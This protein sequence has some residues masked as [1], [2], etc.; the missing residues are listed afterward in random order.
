MIRSLHSLTTTI[1]IGVLLAACG[2]STSAPPSTASPLTS[3]PPGTSP[4]SSPQTAMIPTPGRVAAG[5]EHTCALTSGDGVKCWGANNSGQLGDGTMTAFGVPVTLPADVSGLASGVTA[6]S[7][8]GFHSCA[9]TDAGGVKCWGSNEYGQLGDGT[10]ITS[11]VPVDVS[12][13]ASGVLMISAGWS[14]TCALTSAGGVKCW[15]NNPFGGLGNGT[16]DDSS[17]PVDVSGLDGGI[18]AIA[19]G[20]LHAC[21]LRRTGGVT[22]WGYG[23]SDDPTLFSS[24]LPVEV[25]GLTIGISAIS[26]TLDQTCALRDTGGV[27]CWGPNYA[28]PPGETLPD[29][30]VPVNVA[31]AGG[32]SSIAVGETHSCAL[33][34]LGAVACWGPSL[35]PVDV[36]GLANDVTAIAVG[37]R[38]SCAAT[39][40]GEVK[41]WGEN[42]SG[43]LGTVTRCISTS[44]PVVVRL[45]G[46]GSP[47]PTPEPTWAPSGPIDHPLGPADVVL[48][49]DVGP[50]V[51]VSE[52]GGDQ[53][54]PGPEFSLY[55]DGTI[56]FRDHLAG[57][58]HA[59]GVIVRESPFMISHFDESAVQSLLGFALGEGGLAD[60]C[61]W[62]PPPSDVA[63]LQ[64]G[65]VLSVNGGGVEKQ[66]RVDGPNPVGPLIDRLSGFVPGAGVDAQVWVPG[67]YWGSLFEAAGA[68]EI[69]LL[70]DPR[71]AGSASWPSPAITP[72]E[73]VGRDEGGWIGYPRRVMSADEA[74]VLGLDDNGGVVRRI[75]LVGPDGNTIYAFSMW[76]MMPDEMP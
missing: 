51:A 12:G 63:D 6:I 47:A 37:G 15:G 41:C 61:A 43:Q 33:T 22:C 73:F 58:P 8:G 62:Y 4:T 56:I 46:N 30:F 9:L 52:L 45:A 35:A 7:A 2:P 76:P 38:H 53:F 5:Y 24:S 42:G 74:S 21:A 44:V 10:T 34:S 32:V 18:S 50:D 40:A 67:R 66:V 27:V 65:P 23:Q 36:P 28:P 31:L 72:A 60:A 16:T 55:G 59:E 13:L 19:T 49:M 17:V 39:T 48:R 26:A 3:T 20:V 25:P 68:I 71:E 70:S 54:Q 57:P 69:G 11:S 14:S 29:R 1:L 75:Y 64:P